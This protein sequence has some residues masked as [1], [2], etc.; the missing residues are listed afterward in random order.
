M[1]FQHITGIIFYSLFFNYGNSV[2]QK[3]DKFYRKL[4]NKRPV[5]LFLKVTK[6]DDYSRGRIF[7]EGAYLIT[8]D[9]EDLTKE[10]LNLFLGYTKRRNTTFLLIK[11]VQTNRVLADKNSVRRWKKIK[12]AT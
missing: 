2:N 3:N 4:L 11:T 10:S 5:R 6:E 8:Y 12:T 1:S 7:K 9:L